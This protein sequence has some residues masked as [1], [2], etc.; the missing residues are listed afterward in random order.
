M[1]T[2][3]TL[4]SGGEG[5]GIGAQ[6]AGLRHL[7][8]IEYDDDVAQVARNNGFSVITGDVTTTNPSKLER[9]HIL[10]ASPPCPN[11]SQA[12]VGGA[13]EETDVALARATVR[14]IQAI[15][16]SVFTLENVWQ[17]RKSQSWQIICAE[18]YKC[19]Y[20]V[21]VQHLNTADFGVPQTRKRMIVRAVR[22]GWVPLLPPTESWTGWFEAIADLI[23]GLPETKFAPW[24]LARLGSLQGSTLVDSAGYPGADGVRVAV[25]RCA[26]E[27]ANTIVAN[28][29]RRP[30][31][32]F[33]VSG[34]NSRRQNRGAPRFANEPYFTVTA[35]ASSGKRPR[36]Q[37]ISGRVVQIT[38]H[39][40]ARF[41]TFPDWYEFPDQDR[42]AT[43]VIG[44]A[45]PPL[46]Y[47][48]IA[49]SLKQT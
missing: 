19:G 22:G 46:F 24:Q 21:D 14:F 35:S 28:H 12:K 5:V 49:K 16:P 2:I 34:Q 20:W 36:A 38:S 15:L 3:A 44:N 48:K 30:M 9:P 31:R 8:G 7:W 37:L 47:E 42:L 6:D 11:F 40:L 43:R 1:T 27:P 41:Q 10:H 39:C 25:R 18:L 32:A 26:D 29:A 13:E 17:Y 23:P 4:F 45:V 33:I